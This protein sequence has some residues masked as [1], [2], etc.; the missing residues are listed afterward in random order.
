MNASL[1]EETASQLAA[2][3]SG[4]GQDGD[5]DGDAN[6]RHILCRN[7]TPPPKF[8]NPHPVPAKYKHLTSHGIEKLSIPKPVREKKPK[9][10]K[11]SR[12]ALRYKPTRRVK[13]LARPRTVVGKEPKETTANF[14][15]RP[16]AL[17]QLNQE[18]ETFF[19]DLSLP[20]VRCLLESRNA[21]TKPQQ[22]EKFNR[23][24]DESLRTPYSRLAKTK[25]PPKKG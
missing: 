5:G 8:I 25:L 14:S 16:A 3:N 17:K 19:T 10:M 20:K 7:A 21:S 18:K 2:M 12:Y 9:V 6:Q 22:V 4:D 1:N 13:K 11:I 24:I 15:V 23:L